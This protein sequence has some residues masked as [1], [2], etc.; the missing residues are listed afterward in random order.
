MRWFIGSLI[1]LNLGILAWGWLGDKQP[2]PAELAAP[3]VGTVRLVGEPSADAE[4]VEVPIP[5]P[6]KAV[7]TPGESGGAASPSPTLAAASPQAR[8]LEAE[9]APLPSARL[10]ASEPPAPAKVIDSAPVAAPPPGRPT[11]PAD[12]GATVVDATPVVSAP[13]PAFVP[14]PDV[15]PAAKTA[16]RQCQRIG[17]F[18]SAAAATT[19]RQALA[20]LGTVNSEQISG[21][22]PAGHWV[23]VPPQASRAAALAVAD[24][25]KKK[26]I[27]DLW[28]ISKGAEKN[29]IS[30][31]VFSQRENADRFARRARAKGFDVEIR[32]KTKPG[33]Q[34]WLNY[35]GKTAI[36]TRDIPNTAG[37]SIV[38]RDCP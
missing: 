19:T 20:K 13:E 21:E 30:L 24:R 38:P 15:I 7:G 18:A 29:G 3:G 4:P 28:V 5:A 8:S 31:G 33:K 2:P 6:P 1:A 36:K 14:E 37:V 9:Q 32:I 34:T 12:G 25:L 10:P 16:A 23:L 35:T 17:P 26:G 22:V 27:T 11:A